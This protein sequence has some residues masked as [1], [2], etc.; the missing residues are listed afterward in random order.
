M[1]ECADMGDEDSLAS[2]GRHRKAKSIS[3]HFVKLYSPGSQLCNQGEREYRAA[4]G[5]A[6]LIRAVFGAWRAL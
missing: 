2:S 5:T 3:R 4:E 6:E 1:M